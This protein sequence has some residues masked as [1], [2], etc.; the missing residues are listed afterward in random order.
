MRFLPVLVAI[1]SAWFACP[2]IGQ[3]ALPPLP[4]TAP[5]NKIPTNVLQAIL[6]KR[7][8]ELAAAR[9]SSNAAVALP[10]AQPLPYAP[11]T[12]RLAAVPQTQPR[13]PLQPESYIA[14]DANI[15]STN[16]VAG[17]TNVHFS[18]WLTN[19][20]TEDVLVHSVRTSCGCAVGQL[21]AYPWRLTPGSNG[22]IQVTVNLHGKMGSFSKGVYV[23]SSAGSKTLTV[24]IAMPDSHGTPP[25]M[26]NDRLKN[27]RLAMADRQIVFKG[28]CAKCHSEPAVGKVG[29]DLYAAA[30][31]I[32][33][34]SAHRAALVPDLK[35][36]A[37]P[38]ST[39][40]WRKW[41]AD[42]KPGSMMPAFA[43][44]SGGP[45]SDEQIESVVQ[46]LT[47]NITNKGRQASAASSAGTNVQ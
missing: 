39:E 28:E 27:M 24:Q 29:Q 16:A 2:A 34:D 9:A 42:G 5:R 18:F 46:F 1:V 8:N 40:Y 43:R 35:K 25:G 13:G 41:I 37:V 26:D 19:V 15:K 4:S 44:S 30:C 3:P 20:S 45:L 31:G 12:K 17:L 22:P 36:L 47:E 11:A 10:Q 6:A 7:S 21:P 23:D 32:C 33:H 38:T 14:W